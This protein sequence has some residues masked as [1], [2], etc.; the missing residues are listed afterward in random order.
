[1]KVMFRLDCRLDRWPERPPW[2]EDTA[3]CF[4]SGGRWGAL[5]GLAGLLAVG[6]CSGSGGKGPLP[7]EYPEA[8]DLALVRGPY[9]Q[10]VTEDSVVVMWEATEPCWGVVEGESGGVSVQT[11]PEGPFARHEVLLAGLPGGAAG[12]RYRMRCVTGSEGALWGK[13][14]AA[15]LT[16]WIPFRLAPAPGE[17]FRYLVYGDSRTYVNDHEAVIA[18]MVTEDAALAFN[19]GDVVS[20]GMMGEDLWDTEFFGPAEPLMRSV[21]M[22]VVMGNH[23]QEADNYFDL[24]SQPPPENYFTVSYGDTFHVVLDS[25]GDR[26]AEGSEEI[27]WLDDVL[28]SDEAQ[29]APWLLVYAHHPP[30]SEGWDTPGYDGDENMRN[31]VRP[32]LEAAGVDV[33]FNGHT[34]DYERGEMNGVVWIITGGGGADLDSFQQ[35]FDHITV[36]DSV[37]HY[38]R[39]DVTS[40]E[41]QMTAVSVDGTEID[42]V[43][44]DKP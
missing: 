41:L 26:L 17:P 23:E 34:H 12:A 14:Q 10:N 8:A 5:L 40:T 43:T 42:Q 1:M 32:R 29:S 35:D 18:R 24:L 13:P 6:G 31:V 36:Y 16:E 22:F 7:D 19:T 44:L 11:E 25:N 4:R 39:V 9:L 37:H 33:V 15:V 28:S 3:G 2:T 30:Y 20:F 27:A 38:V 21:P